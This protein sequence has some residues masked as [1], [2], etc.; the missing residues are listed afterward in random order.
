MHQIAFQCCTDDCVCHDPVVSAGAP[1]ATNDDDNTV[2][3]AANSGTAN[4]NPSSSS[5]TEAVAVVGAVGSVM[6]LGAV[7]VI[8]YGRRQDISQEQQQHQQLGELLTEDA[9]SLL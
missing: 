6:V 1:S 9:I 3:E 8:A 2:A 7:A 4:S 5:S